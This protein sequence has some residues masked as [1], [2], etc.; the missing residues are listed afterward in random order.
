MLKFGDWWAQVDDRFIEYLQFKEN[1]YRDMPLFE[2]D[3]EVMIKDGP[4][5][6]IEAIYL[7]ANGDERAMVLLT[8][9]GRKQSVVV[10]ECL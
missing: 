1:G 7:C 4:F 5:K 6:G 9:L 3:Q 8:L 10:D 2:P